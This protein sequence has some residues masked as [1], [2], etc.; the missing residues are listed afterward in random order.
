MMILHGKHTGKSV[1]W[2]VLKDPSYTWWVLNEPNANGWLIPARQEALR[3]LNIFDRKRFLKKCTE[4]KERVATKASFC[5]DSPIPLWW[6]NECEP[7]LTE[8]LK[9]R[10]HTVITYTQAFDHIRD[11]SRGR[12]GDLNYLIHLLAE[13]K[14]LLKRVGEKQARSFFFV[15]TGRERV[16]S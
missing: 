14:G 9:G 13:A 15:D 3:L 5:D 12:K 1:E 10:I 11:Y 16:V 7:D 2:V 6:C 4:C 8:T